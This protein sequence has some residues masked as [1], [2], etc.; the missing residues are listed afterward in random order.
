[1]IV[2]QIAAQSSNRVIGI[3]NNLPWNIPEDLNYFK[4]KTKEKIII[5][6]RKTFES[7]PKM[8][9]K[10]FHIVISRNPKLEKKENILWVNSLESALDQAKKLIP[11]WPEE[12]FII[13]GGEIFLQALPCTQRIYLTQIHKEYDGDAFFPEFDKNIFKMVSKIKGSSS[14]LDNQSL[15]FDYLVFEK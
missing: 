10:R 6:G 4:E 14:K 12:I 1:M 13:G 3:H 5:M 15:Q 9:P 11:P 7:L 2:S 8:L